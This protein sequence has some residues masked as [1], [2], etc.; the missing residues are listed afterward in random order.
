[1]ALSKYLE[2]F[3]GQSRIVRAK[4]EDNILLMEITPI[5]TNQF[6]IRCSLTTHSG[7]RLSK[8]E[9]FGSISLQT[10]PNTLD[11]LYINI[12]EKVVD[13]ASGDVPV[14]E[15]VRQLQKLPEEYDLTLICA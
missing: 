13:K 2:S 14:G 10:L 8:R 1:M 15:V 12:A 7:A 6:A 4:I 5:T 11:D 9:D 3:I